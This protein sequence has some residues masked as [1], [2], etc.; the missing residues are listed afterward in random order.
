MVIG[1]VHVLVPS[2]DIPWTKTSAVDRPSFLAHV[3]WS[4]GTGAAVAHPPK[5]TRARTTT[6]EARTAARLR[7]GRLDIDI[8]TGFYRAGPPPA[9]LGHQALSPHGPH[10]PSSSSFPFE[11]RVGDVVLEDGAR[12]R[13]GRPTATAAARPREPGCPPGRRDGPAGGDLGDVAE[14]ARGPPRGP[15]LARSRRPSR[16]RRQASPNPPGAPPRRAR[17]RGGRD[18][19]A[20]RP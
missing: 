5:T 7:R 3:G 9:R 4:C 14:G 11:L 10:S 12:A 20:P 16:R 17:R 6:P 19:G 18:G 8:G 15:Q 13:V 1:F 2:P